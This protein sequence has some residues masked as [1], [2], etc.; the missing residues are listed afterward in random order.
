[1][2]GHSPGHSSADGAKLPGAEAAQVE[3]VVRS[4]AA[5]LRSYRLYDGNG[6]T[7]ERFVETLRQKLSALWDVLPALHLQIEEERIL[8]EGGTVL[9]AS[10]SSS[11]LPFLLYRDGIREL[12]LLPGL[13]E[14]EATR[15]LRVLAQA[16]A[17]RQ[18]EDDLITVLWEQDFQQLR[19]RVVEA[20]AEG[21]EIGAGNGGQPA[22]V[23][24][25]AVRAA[26]KDGG[27]DITAEDF[28][29]TLHFLDPAE[30]RKLRDEVR[31]ENE[32]D[33]W[34][35]LLNALLDRLEDADPPRQVRII[36]I[37]SE[38]LPSALATAEFGRAAFLLRQLADFAGRPGAL[39][40][41]ALREIRAL[42]EEL[43]SDSTIAQLAEILE[44]MPDRLSDPA[45]L[46]IL[47]F[48]PPRAIGSLMTASEKVQRPEVRRAFEACVQRLADSNREAVVAL[49]RSEDPVVLVGALKWVGRLE[50]GSALNDVV[51]F[52]GFPDPAV[53]ATAAEALLPLRGAAAAKSLIPLLQ[54][55]ER[56]VRIAA[57]QT[58]GSLAYAPGRAAL[59]SAIAS[60]RLREAD[61]S[62]KVAF[63]EAYGRLAGPEGVDFLDKILNSRGWLGRGEPAD[64]RAA[65]ALALAKIRNPAARESLSAAAN[66]SDPVVRSA[67]A[68]ALRGEAGA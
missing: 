54:D 46:Q 5:A 7:L 23:D 34:T 56:R 3:D 49:L 44:E 52:L 33:L 9:L 17:M 20:A 25:A 35:D 14:E 59:E 1:M 21:V 36:S 4:L 67:V 55:S 15:L 45:V 29:E 24:P 31:R 10:E 39:A 27:A 60:K 61:R 22:A 42:F 48:F 2:M 64:L 57:A 43:G 26:A 41:Q 53:R 11:D 28:Q 62:E 37:L 13:E 18:D 6:P 63:F 12:T 66:D 58:L 8:W 47:Q 50:L 30:L 19:Y 65:A 38:L 32:R 68:R 16:P 51:R 40:P